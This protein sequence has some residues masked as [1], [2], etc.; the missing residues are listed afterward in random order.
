[1]YMIT[2]MVV[3]DWSDFKNSGAYA[4]QY[5]QIYEGVEHMGNSYHALFKVDLSDYALGKLK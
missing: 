3:R 4:F 1:M 5:V 2:P